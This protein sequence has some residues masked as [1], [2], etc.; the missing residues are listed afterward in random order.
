[1]VFKLD[2]IDGIEAYTITSSNRQ[3][4]NVVHLNYENV[5]KEGL[6]ELGLDKIDSI[7]Y[8]KSHM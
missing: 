7:K 1:M 4:I 8:L 5:I 6:M 3:K 2:N